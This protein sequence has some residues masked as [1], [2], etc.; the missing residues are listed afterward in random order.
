LVSG[1]VALAVGFET[2][3]HPADYTLTQTAVAVGL[4]L[5]LFLVSTAGALHRALGCILWN[6]LIVLV[7]TLGGL[8]VSASSSRHQILGVA[9]VGLLVIVTIE[10]MTIRRELASP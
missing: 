7:L 8:A 5:T 1:I 4:G 2:A 9:C 10:Q 3:L 6:R